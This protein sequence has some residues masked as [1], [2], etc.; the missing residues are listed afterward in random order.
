MSTDLNPQSGY[1][2][3]DFAACCLNGRNFCRA[4]K[5]IR[6]Q[7]SKKPPA[8]VRSEELTGPGWARSEPLLRRE[9]SSGLG[10]RTASAARQR[11]SNVDLLGDAQR[12]F[13]FDTE[14]SDRAVNFGMPEQKLNRSEVSGFPVNLCRLGPTKRVGSVS[15]RFQPNRGHPIPHKPTILAR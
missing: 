13:K 15:A 9:R 12:I 4:A 8:C 5:P 7:C 10:W 14:V 1:F 11:A 2:E 3:F 6:R